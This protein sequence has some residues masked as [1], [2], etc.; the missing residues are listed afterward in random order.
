MKNR[1]SSFTQDKCVGAILCDREGYCFLAHAVMRAMR[2]FNLS[3]DDWAHCLLR[4]GEL[5]DQGLC[6]KAELVQTAISEAVQQRPVSRGKKLH[7][8]RHVRPGTTVFERYGI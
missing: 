8:E 3:G 2:E 7:I 6:Q 5:V 1:E 4:T